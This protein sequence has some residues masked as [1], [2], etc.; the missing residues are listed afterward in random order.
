MSAVA[1]AFEAASQQVA[2]QLA[3]DTAAAVAKD[4]AQKQKADSA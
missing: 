3:R 4:R 1:Q 2:Q